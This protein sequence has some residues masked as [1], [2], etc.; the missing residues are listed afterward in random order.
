MT[1]T[2]LNSPTAEK[3][4]GGDLLYGKFNEKHG[5][6][7]SDVGRADLDKHGIVLAL[8]RLGL[9]GFGRQCVPNIGGLL[10]VFDRR[11]GSYLL[12]RHGQF[13]FD[14]FLQPR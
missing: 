5:A 9:G 12:L 8:I 3:A 2:P 4:D 13:L 14:G 7:L 6:P 11:V 1:N 10:R